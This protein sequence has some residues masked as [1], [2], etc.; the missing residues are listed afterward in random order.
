MKTC[1]AIGNTAQVG[2][3]PRSLCNVGEL[4]A[5][6]WLSVEGWHCLVDSDGVQRKRRRLFAA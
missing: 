6:F 1:I 5:E 4:I 3:A 2:Q